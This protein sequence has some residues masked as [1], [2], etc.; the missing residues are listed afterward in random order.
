MSNS[1]IIWEIFLLRQHSLIELKKRSQ[2]DWSESRFDTL[3]NEL[4]HKIEIVRGERRNYSQFNWSRVYVT[5]N[6]YTFST[7]T[8]SLYTRWSNDKTTDSFVRTRTTFIRCW[9]RW[10]SMHVCIR[11]SLICFE[12]QKTTLIWKKHL[13]MINRLQNSI[14]HIDEKTYAL[15]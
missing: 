8:S 12:W 13:T 5:L 14:C 10:F 3:S 2:L 11:M 6:Q 15:D 7:H 4:F 9:I 1:Y